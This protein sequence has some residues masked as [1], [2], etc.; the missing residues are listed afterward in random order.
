MAV[1]PHQ[2]FSEKTDAAERGAVL[3]A[4]RPGSSAGLSRLRN[5]RADSRSAIAVVDDFSLAGSGFDP[6]PSRRRSR[7]NADRGLAM[8]ADHRV[9]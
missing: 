8:A 1:Y 4:D 6:R 7:Y 3:K 2:F 9:T 5:D